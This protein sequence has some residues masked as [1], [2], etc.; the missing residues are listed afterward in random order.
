MSHPE[1]FSMDSQPEDV[2][3]GMDE[4]EWTLSESEAQ[5]LRD[6]AHNHSLTLNSILLGVLGLLFARYNDSRSV[7]VGTTVAGRP[8]ELPGSTS[9]VGLFIN[10]LPVRI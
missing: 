6:F 3:Q 9:M 7:V 5:K 4:L 8:P 2:S 1:D 10:T